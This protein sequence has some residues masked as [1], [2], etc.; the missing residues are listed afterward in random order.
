ME[1]KDKP[2]AAD[3]ARMYQGVG[4]AMTAGDAEMEIVK[5]GGGNWAEHQWV[6]EQLRVAH[7]QQGD[8]SDAIA[9]NYALYQQYR[10][11]LE[12]TL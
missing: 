7:V 4:S 5:T 10:D 6:K 3:I 9:H 8:G 12:D 2:S 1:G 11:A